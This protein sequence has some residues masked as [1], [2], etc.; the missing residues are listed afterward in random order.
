M[1]EGKY[2]V[3]RKI[4]DKTLYQVKLRQVEKLNKAKTQEQKN[5]I[6]A[7]PINVFVTALDN[8]KPLLKII[9][10]KRGGI[11]YQVPVPMSEKEREFKATKLIISSCVEKDKTMRLY[12][13]LAIELIE[14]SKNE[15][16][17]PIIF[18]LLKGK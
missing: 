12:N 2:A 11:S 8:C 6:E 4:M 9:S 17:K 1:R 18:F 14:A 15:V 5:E 16:N 3:C 10:M 7:N 13:R